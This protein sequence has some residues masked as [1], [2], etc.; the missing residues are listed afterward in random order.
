[1]PLHMGISGLETY[2]EYCRELSESDRGKARNLMQQ[3]F[4][5][6]VMRYMLEQNCKLEQ[7]IIS[8]GIVKKSR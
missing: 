5:A 6:E 1:M 2:R 4:Y 8:Y 3:E 7:E